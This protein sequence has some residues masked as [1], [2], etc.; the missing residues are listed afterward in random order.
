[1]FNKSNIVLQLLLL[2]IFYKWWQD[3]SFKG[4]GL[5]DTRPETPETPIDQGDDWDAMFEEW[6]D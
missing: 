1:M 3:H 2:C 6:F 5:G 4:F